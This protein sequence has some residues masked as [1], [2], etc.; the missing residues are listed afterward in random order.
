MKLKKALLAM[1]GILVFITNPVFSI[2]PILPLKSKKQLKNRS[3]SSKP[4]SLQKPKLTKT[5][6]RT[7]TAHWGRYV[8]G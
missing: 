5:S 2:K 1:L 7:C 3:I 8:V 6:Q 4:A